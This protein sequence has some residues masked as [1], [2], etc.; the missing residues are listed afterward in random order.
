MKYKKKKVVQRKQPNYIVIGLAI[1]MVAIMLYQSGNLQLGI[2]YL[3]V[4]SF[5]T[6]ALVGLG[7][8]NIF[9]NHI[10]IK[11]ALFVLAFLSVYP[12]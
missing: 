4:P 6:I 2:D 5:F 9:S 7:I 10:I 1:A 11:I 8:I 12:V 3:T